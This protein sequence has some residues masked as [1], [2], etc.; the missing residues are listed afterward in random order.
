[1]KRIAVFAFMCCVAAA[2]CGCSSN[3]SNSSENLQISTE[4]GVPF[5]EEAG[6]VMVGTGTDPELENQIIVK[7]TEEDQTEAFSQNSLPG[8]K[9]GIMVD[10]TEEENLSVG[11]AKSGAENPAQEVIESETVKQ[12]E[13]SFGT[14]EEKPAGEIL[15]EEDG[16]Q[17][18]KA[19]ETEAGKQSGKTSETEEGK[20][21]EK[22]S[23]T[24][25]GKQSEK[26]SETEE[27]KQTEKASETEE[28][29]QTEKT[30]ETEEGKQAEESA[31]T[32]SEEKALAS[33]KV[34]SEETESE[35]SGENMKEKMENKKENGPITQILDEVISDREKNGE[36]W[37]VSYED[38]STGEVYCYEDDAVMKSASTIK[39]FIMGA[40]Y[41]YMCYPEEGEE[42]VDFH[43]EY[44]GHLRD[45]I[46][47]MI[48]VSD[49]DSANLLVDR[50]GGGYF[51]EGS[52]KVKEFCEKY[53]YKETIL[54][55]RFLEFSSTSDNVTSAGDIGKILSDIYHGRLINEEASEKMLEILK[56][57]TRKNKIPSGLPSD[58]TSA[59]KTGE[60][61]DGYGVISVENDCAIVFPPEGKGEGYILVVLSNN[62]NGKND[63]AISSI[64]RISSIAADYYMEQYEE[65]NG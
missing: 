6:D 55:R 17:T 63:E 36:K 13:V 44:D 11:T 9:D 56:G 64:V 2:V 53:G 61:A 8:I 42:V 52:K 60:I 35:I 25:E 32:E 37:S 34:Q 21:S 29:K 49:N 51:S 16:K 5:I 43:E 31:E 57:Q 62:L 20:Q 26:A 58:F 54:G 15:A 40:V 14:E 48:T 30:S 19:S 41:Q 27:G 10:E 3:S 50:L 1:M 46:E 47:A 7:N 22:A 45:T 4:D 12:S 24:E 65:K 59:N 23:E 38:L 33:G 39:L 28:G 18:E